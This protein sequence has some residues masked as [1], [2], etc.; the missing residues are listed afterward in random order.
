MTYY[1]AT[2][3]LVPYLTLRTFLPLFMTAMAARFGPFWGFLADLEG[4]QLLSSIPS[5]LTQDSTLLILGVLAGLEIAAQ[6]NPEVREF[7]TLFESKVK[8]IAAFLVSFSMVG[9]DSATLAGHLEQ[10][11]L[12]TQFAW[13]Q[14]LA[15]TWSFGV[16][17]VVWFAAASRSFILT[18]LIELDEDD[19]LGLQ[20]FLSWLEDLIG[21]FG[22]LFVFLLPLASVFVVGATLVGLYLTRRYLEHR[23]Q[24]DRV[25]CTACQTPMAPCAVQCGRCRQPNTFPLQVGW[26]GRLLDK[27]ARNLEVHQQNLLARK[28]C[29][30]CGERFVDRRVDQ[31]CTTCGAS[32][33]A[34]E[35]DLE[36]YLQALQESLPKTL[37]ILLL[38]SFV[39]VLGLIPGVIY[40]R[41][42]LIASLRCY[43]PRASNF[44]MRWV[45]R[46][47]NLVLICLQPIPLLGMLTLPLMCL[48]NFYVYRSALRRQGRL[49]L[50]RQEIPAIA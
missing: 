23:E 1:L 37:A 9:G 4:I 27:P 19:D 8:A 16:G 11:G 45:V 28:R 5:A 40:Y 31:R 41:C 26:F 29:A 33:F 30:S 42:S 17:F 6:K 21:F 20:G 22:V 12:T 38:L 44:V 15:Y 25:P 46:F 13:G 49:R 32:P 14:G 43:L 47:V 24:A 18:S 10:S 35:R 7:M 39:P 36:V 2:L 3:G 48:T 34:S 50:H